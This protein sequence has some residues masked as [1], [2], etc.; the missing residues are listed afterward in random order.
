MSCFISSAAVAYSINRLGVFSCVKMWCGSTW[1]ACWVVL[2]QSALSGNTREMMPPPLPA[3]AAKSLDLWVITETLLTQYTHTHVNPFQHTKATQRRTAQIWTHGC[4]DARSHTHQTASKTNCIVLA[5][6]ADSTHTAT[7]IYFI[8]E[9]ELLF[10]AEVNHSGQELT[11]PNS[12]KWLH[13]ETQRDDGHGPGR[14]GGSLCRPLSCLWP[15]RIS[16]RL[17]PFMG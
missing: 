2:L 4:A 3:S 13:M 9:P 7:N 17:L 14:S 16:F 11:P 8:S 15:S 1:W 6:T 12:W 5:Q 10:M